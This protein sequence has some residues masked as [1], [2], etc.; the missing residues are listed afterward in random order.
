MREQRARL[1]EHERAVA[2]SDPANWGKQDEPEDTPVEL[3]SVQVRVEP[4][5]PRPRRVKREAAVPIV[6]GEGGEFNAINVERG[7]PGA[8]PSTLLNVR[9]KAGEQGK[10]VKAADQAELPLSVWAR[11]VL[12][13][14]AG[15]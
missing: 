10:L 4:I 2:G 12:L 14:E 5:L 6:S 13:R 7:V 8:G 9:L 11:E 15:K 1:L 3:D